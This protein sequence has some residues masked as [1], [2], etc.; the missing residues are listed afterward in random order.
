MPCG[1][2]VP[3]SQVDIYRAILTR[4]HTYPE[5]IPCSPALKNLLDRM[6]AKDPTRRLN[7]DV[8]PQRAR[9]T[10]Y[11]DWSISCWHAEQELITLV[12]KL[13]NPALPGLPLMQLPSHRRR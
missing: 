1:G 7:L 4:P 10:I 9:F 6:L 12:S 13:L 3:C 5:D 2:P 8:R 11:L